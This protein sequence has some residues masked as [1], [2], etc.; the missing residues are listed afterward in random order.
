[1][2]RTILAGILG[3][4]AM[5]LW[6]GIAHTALPLGEAGIQQIQNED[7]LLAAMQTALPSHGFYMFPNMPPGMSQEQYQGKVTNGP[8][9]LLIYFP[10]RDF[11]FG[12]SLAVEFGTELLMALLVTYLLSTSSA[13]SFGAR[14]G[15]VALA[16]VIGACGTNLSYWNWYGFPSKYTAAYVFTIWIGYVFAGLVAASM[17]IGGAHARTA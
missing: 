16:G 12:R 2:K 5:F 9:G 17:K 8:S 14:F 4:V 13:G 3:G 1:M 11:S 15:F 6:S 10:K 7:P